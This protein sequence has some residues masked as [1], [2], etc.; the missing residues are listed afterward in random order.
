[1]S[2]CA[3]LDVAAVDLLAHG[4]EAVL[5]ADDNA[6]DLPGAFA[7]VLGPQRGVAALADQTADLAVK[8]A[9]GIADQMRRLARRFGQALDLVGDHR[10]AASRRTGAGGLDG[11]VQRQQV[12]LLGDRLDRTGYLGH[13]RQRGSDRAETVLDAADRLDQF[14]DVL[15]RRLHRSAR[16]H[17][18]A[19][20]GR[21]GGLHRARRGGDVV[22]GGDHGLGGLLQMPE[23]VGLGDDP[24]GD[25]L[26]VS[27]HIR[28]LDAK[29]ADPVRQLV[30]QTFAVRGGGRVR[31]GRLRNRHRC[32]SPVTR[33]ED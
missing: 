10:K 3:R 25:F 17:D 14:G 12:G 33:R 20:G 9:N 16:L 2:Q 27:R 32:N 1:M 26:Q 31:L 8:I 21:G 29:A 4:S 30:D 11:R 18:L 6:L 22:I 5:D 15:H 7:G 28:E 24:A 13:L 19:D 23:A